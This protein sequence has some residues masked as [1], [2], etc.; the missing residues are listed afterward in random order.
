MEYTVEICHIDDM[1]FKK[2]ENV[3]F[4]SLISTIKSFELKDFPMIEEFFLNFLEAI[5]TGKNI[6]S[7]LEIGDQFPFDIPSSIPIMSFGG[8]RQIGSVGYELILTRT[9]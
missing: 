6:S 9:K 5:K 2:I 3:K 7:K 8:L 4:S 1:D